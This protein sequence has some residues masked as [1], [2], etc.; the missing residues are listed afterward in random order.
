MFALVDVRATGLSG[1]DF[2]RRLLDEEHVAVM[3]GESFGAT[4]SGWLR[5]SLTRPDD[6]IEEACSRMARFAARVTEG[7]G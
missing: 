5:V 2:A 7:R 3:P 1:D 6:E 4:L